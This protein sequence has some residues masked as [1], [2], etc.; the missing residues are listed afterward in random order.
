M[1]RQAFFHTLWENV[2]NWI[3]LNSHLVDF[4][5]RKRCWM[6]HQAAFTRSLRRWAWI[7]LERRPDCVHGSSQILGTFANR[8]LIGAWCSHVFMMFTN[9]CKQSLLFIS[10]YHVNVNFV[11]DKYVGNFWVGPG[12]SP[13]QLCSGLADSYLGQVGM[14]KS[15]LCR[16]VMMYSLGGFYFDTVPWRDVR[17]EGNVAG[18]YQ[19]WRPPAGDHCEMRTE[20]EFGERYTKKTPWSL[21]SR[22]AGPFFKQYM[23]KPLFW[24]MPWQAKMATVLKKLNG[25]QQCESAIASAH[26]ENVDVLETLILS[27]C[28]VTAGAVV[29]F[30]L[31][32]KLRT[33]FAQLG[34]ALG[35]QSHLCNC[36]W[37][38]FS[39]PL[40]VRRLLVLCLC[41]TDTYR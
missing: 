11:K 21:R 17:L 1:L 7:L 18:D 2:T 38:D 36:S 27:R 31:P 40:E 26:F 8:G 3:H 5:W 23:A 32:E 6:T 4:S 33:S 14:V 25:R 37:A 10:V 41:T 29:S 28:V 13:S 19:I 12:M 20:Q 9:I 34:A 30:R 39:G 22:V 15:D 16:L 35:A 24:G